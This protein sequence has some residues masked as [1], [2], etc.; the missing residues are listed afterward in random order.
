MADIAQIGFFTDTSDLVDAERKLDALVPAAAGAEKSANKLTSAFDRLSTGGTLLSRVFGGMQSVFAGVT[1]GVKGFFATLAAGFAA[2]E[3]ISGARELSKSIAELTT[4]FPAGSKEIEKI[5]EAA[6]RMAREFGTSQAAQI[7]ATFEAVSAGATST[8]AAID[9]VDNANK[10][11]IGG[12]T[13]I[14]TA[15]DVLTGIVNAYEGTNYDAAQASDALFVAVAA[16]KTRIRE[17][18]QYLGEVIPTA[19]NAGI[20]FDELAAAIAALTLGSIRTPQAATALNAFLNSVLKPSAEAT[21]L[22]KQLGIQYDVTALKTKGLSGFL[23]DLSDKTKGNSTAF[24]ILAGGS[25]ALKSVL[26]LTANEGAKFDGILEKMASKAG[27]TK[28]AFDKVSNSLEFRFNRLLQSAASAATAMGYIILAAIVPIGEAIE[29]LIMG[30]SPLSPLLNEVATVLM[31]AFG[32]VALGAIAS[33][34]MGVATITASIVGGLIPALS[35]AVTAMITFAAAN[36]FT[37]LAVALGTVLAAAYVFRDKIKQIF[38]VDIVSTA[39]NGANMIAAA[40]IGAYNGVIAVWSGL[41]AAMKDIVLSAANYV[42]L[43]TRK[44]INNLVMSVNGLLSNLPDW[45]GGGENVIKYTLELDDAI[46]NDAKGKAA[47]VGKVFSGEMSK[48]FETDW[49]GKL[50]GAADAVKGKLGELADDASGAKDQIK[51]MLNVPTSGGMDLAKGAGAG[52]GAGSGSTFR[53]L[54][55]LQQ[56]AKDLDT[57]KDPYDQ[58]A[59]AF[60]A[61][62]SAMDAGVISNDQYASSL[63]RIEQA[64]LRVGG[65]SA[66][67]SNIVGSNTAIVNHQLTELAENSLNRLGDEFINLAVDGKANFADLARSI[68]KD[69]LKIA[70]QALITRSIM[71]FFRGNPGNGAL[72]ILPN[73]KGGVYEFANGGAFTNSIV[74]KPTLF[75]F[76]NGGALGVMGEAGPEAIM[77]LQRGPD[78]SLGVQMYGGARP[79]T[80]TSNEVTV[81]NSYVISGAISSKEITEQIRAS[82]ENTKETVKKSVVQWLDQYNQDGTI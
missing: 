38:G 43:A 27:A 47:E 78:G 30:T 58:A 4:A 51:Q 80:P 46:V 11:A 20:G 44:M 76:A 29:K 6:A 9:L 36:P 72:N 52:A 1:Q 24:A 35:A 50:G 26:S 71:G 65:T 60:S 81:N 48:A 18:A 41:G 45:L 74:A 73:A 33:M 32:P 23:K 3:A 63:A 25:E 21:D 28:E 75:A 13:D 8:A 19:A 16:G 5:T 55:E 64:F 17:M 79:T 31:I 66:Q 15:V 40:L 61:L 22:A 49:V 54:T 39:K 37:A 82:A 70:W 53:A 7:T 69:L 12:F 14:S 10:L 56:I 68:V 77:P 67:W 2:N 57:L 62:R 42:I 34:A 59:N